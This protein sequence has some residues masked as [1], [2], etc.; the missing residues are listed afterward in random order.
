MIGKNGIKTGLLGLIVL[1]CATNT[2]INAASAQNIANAFAADATVNE[3]TPPALLDDNAAFNTTHS[4]AAQTARVTLLSH[5]K[6]QQPKVIKAQVVNPHTNNINSRPIPIKTLLTN[7][8]KDRQPVKTINETSETSPRI[9]AASIMPPPL[10]KKAPAPRS[11]LI[12]LNFNN[13]RTREL[14]Q[15][16]SQF[17]NLNFVVSDAV[18]GEMSIHLD[19]VPWQEAL[20]VILNAQGL[21]ERHVGSILLIAPI[22]DLAAYDIEKLRASKQIEK[23]EPLNNMIMRLRY[24]NAENVAKMLADG[25]KPM[26]TNRGSVTY[27]PRSNSLW[28]RDVPQK[29]KMLHSI[30]ARLDQPAKQVVIDARI[31]EIQ[32]NFERE[33]GARFGIT[34]GN[35]LSGTFSGANQRAIG[36]PPGLITPATDR[37]NFNMPAAPSF[38]RAGSIALALAKVGDSYLDL[39]LSALEQ[40]GKIHLVSNP[41]LITSNLHPS[42][43]QTGEEIPYQEA[44]ASGATAVQFKDAVLS[45]KVTPQIT[46]DKRVILHLQVSNNRAGKA[47]KLEGGGEAIPIVTQ[48]EQSRVLLNDGQTIVLG[49]IYTQDKRNIYTRIPFFGTLPLVGR[50]FTHQTKVNKR[51]ELLIFI[52]PH[53][54][55]KP[56]EL[57]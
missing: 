1:C 40:E 22:Q 33:F 53:I 55:N 46:P 47:V 12:S 56:S 2:A 36:V 54:V 8:I 31:V 29:L 19:K 15:I 35:N 26:I 17:V 57:S 16:I 24:A 3:A 45:L 43:I 49:G 42:Y 11:D 27:D 9:H 51:L 21:A 10:T 32:R 23:L 30:V 52:T 48:E 38:G 41:R 39:E 50:L 28:I 7:L 4:P 13:I 18:K 14:L 5:A 44:T 20:N 34:S 6:T 37:L 25:A